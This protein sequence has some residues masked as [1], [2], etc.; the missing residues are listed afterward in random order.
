IR[1]KCRLHVGDEEVPIATERLRL[2]LLLGFAAGEPAIDVGAEGEG[3]VVDVVKSRLEVFGDFPSML[4]RGLF[5]GEQ[6]SMPF[7]VNV[8]VI[9]FPLLA[10]LAEPH[11]DFPPSPFRHRQRLRRLVVSVGW[12]ARVVLTTSRMNR[13]VDG[14]MPS[15]PVSHF[16]TVT[17]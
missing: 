11:H 7:A 9:D 4:V 16:L 17:M 8:A 6:R 3:G 12:G 1:S 15:F 14:R 5:G 13:S 2:D 10:V